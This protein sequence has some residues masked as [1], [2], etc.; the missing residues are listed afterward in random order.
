M[1]KMYQSPKTET[2]EVGNYL[3]LTESQLTQGVQSQGDPDVEY[4][5][6]DEEGTQTPGVHGEQPFAFSWE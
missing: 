3:M 2:M 6:T 4:G 1:K 5:G